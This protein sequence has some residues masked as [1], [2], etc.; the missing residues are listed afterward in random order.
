MRDLASNTTGSGE[1]EVKS[2]N[3]VNFGV[4][5]K[6][7][8][9]WNDMVRWCKELRMFLLANSIVYE[10]WKDPLESPVYSKDSQFFKTI[11]IV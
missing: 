9:A 5:N 2:E 11:N 1:K 7:R 3:S 6:Q 8:A 4:F 10:S